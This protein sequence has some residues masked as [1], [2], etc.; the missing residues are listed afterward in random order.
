MHTFGPIDNIMHI[1]YYK[2]GPLLN[3]IECFYIHKEVATDNQL[4]DKQTI[5]PNKIFDAIL[6]IET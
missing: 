6:N 5:F 2:K 4:N 1:L 3:T